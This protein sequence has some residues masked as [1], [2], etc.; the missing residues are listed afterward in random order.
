MQMRRL[1]PLLIPALLLVIAMMPSC[2]GGSGSTPAATAN[3]PGAR[4]I[5]ITVCDGPP[6]SPM[7][8]RVP[9]AP[10]SGA[11]SDSIAQ[12]NTI[13]FHAVA[14]R[15]N[16]KLKDI[17]NAPTT[18]WTSDNPGVAQALVSQQGAFVGASQGC[19]CISASAGGRSS[20]LVGIAVFASATPECSPCE[21]PGP[22][23]TAA[24]P[25]SAAAT[26]TPAVDAQP[27]AGR[28]GVL[29]WTFNAYA[30]ILAPIVPDGDGGV[31]FVSS[32][33]ILHALDADG[34]E[35]F[36][37]PARAIAA[38]PQSQD[39]IYIQGVDGALH[40][41]TTSGAELWHLQDG[42][43][44]GPLAVA[45]DGDADADGDLYAAAGAALL[46]VSRD[47][48]LNWRV[49]LDGQV[50]GRVTAIAPLAGGGVVAGVAGARVTAL[51][52]GG[53]ERWSFAPKG[54]FSGAIAIAGQIAYA[55]SSSGTLHAIAV[56]SGAELNR[57]A[58]NPGGANA[59]IRSG[60]VIAQGGILYFGS[61]RFYAIAAGGTRVWRSDIVEG[62]D[63][64]PV[65]L[66][67]G[68]VLIAGASG[69]VASVEADGSYRWGARI[70]EPVSAAAA[71]ASE[72]I[73]VGGDDGILYA[74]R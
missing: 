57:L 53:A 29:Q 49:A 31:Y 68:R 67:N 74:I 28:A 26:P 22:T 58:V 23:S 38:Q 63:A 40:A 73:Y 62:G 17:T 21:T 35:R 14:K 11:I 47:G 27:D 12:G 2:G 41:L 71:G 24:T 34:R 25:T 46:S 10:C 54:G 4:L 42:G 7:A 37:R 36:R 5:S 19:A 66:G 32:D 48:V 52:R 15:T 39:T 3:P 64:A 45:P 20:N 30:P 69:M 60:P 51:S 55:G 13:A 6:A 8:T 16:R 59:P 61:D 43:A 70:G 33:G 1:G 18:L 50:A 9:P 65:L 44:R 72:L 56:A